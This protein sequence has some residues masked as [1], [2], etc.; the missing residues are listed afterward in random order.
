MPLQFVCP[1]GHR[2]QSVTEGG[3]VCP[4]CGAASGV[5]TAVGVGGTARGDKLPPP[6]GGD[7][8]PTL[9]PPLAGQR[10][11]AWP[12]VPGFEIRGVAG[13]GGM[14][15]VYRA[16]QLSLKREVAL[17][18]V[19]SDAEAGDPETT[20]F[21]LEAESVA[22]LNHPNVVHVYDIVEADGRLYC[23]LEYVPGGSL[24]DR[25]AAGRL[26]LRE[27]VA[28]VEVLARAMH[29]VHQRHIV[30][31]DLKPGNVLLGADGTLK[32]TDF[33]LAKRLDQVSQHTP[34]GAMLGTP[35]Y[36]APEQ[37]R[38]EIK[39]IGP[40]AD[41]YALGVIL[42]ELLT[43]RC[44]F[45]GTLL[46]VLLKINSDAPV[47]P[48]H[49]N[50][51]VP[52]E[53]ETICLKCMEKEPVRR[54]PSAAD[55]AQALRQ[56]LL[57]LPQDAPT[58]AAV[59]VTAPASP[60]VTAPAP[61]PPAAPAE[62]ARPGGRR[63]RRL[64]LAALALGVVVTAAVPLVKWAWD[65]I[66]NRGTSKGAWAVFAIDGRPGE[67]FDRIAFPG[68][69]VGYAAG[70]Q[71]VRK[72][73]DSGQTW[74]PV[75]ERKPPGRTHLLY[76]QNER[77]GWLGAERLYQTGD[78]GDTWSEVSLPERTGVVSGLAID[79]NGWALVGGNLPGP[80]G[81]L[82]LF[83]Q[84]GG[85]A[86]WE[87]LDPVKTG[88]WGGDQ[89][90]FRRWFVGD[91]KSTGPRVA[92]LVLLA[93]YEDRGAVLR[94]GD[95]GDTWKAVLT[96]ENELYR[97]SFADGQRGWLTG[98]RGALWRTADGGRNWAPQPPPAEDP[99]GGLAF[100]P[101]REVFGLAPLWQGQVLKTT[102]GEYW[103]TV[104][105][106]LGYS[107]PDVAVVDRGCAYVLS[108]DGRIARY[109]DPS[110]PPSK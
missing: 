1:R 66:H 24:K 23:A 68:R 94:T 56:V 41:V 32:I 90:P 9:F 35:G 72:T 103:Q 44:P 84:R 13:K 18:C 61:P 38:G 29:Y 25:L 92:L 27:A 110:V 48:S 109:L 108:A 55:L 69:A 12:A 40:A 15:L 75:W 21:R 87:K 49:L 106:D 17:K 47:P 10:P 77:V 50:A 88:Y 37:A 52:A 53:L 3:S 95:G 91:I 36:M 16:W 30:H 83:R 4:E 93:G 82:V 71:A 102:D 26:P 104:Q 78:G 67:V 65:R 74:R 19:L 85:Q 33:G 51:A 107:L 2:W 62:P 31:R 100:A 105:V 45:Q 43:G 64:V 20:R 99:L 6:A 34:D 73:E 54:Y 8:V 86:G 97:A 11:P 60:S 81:D 98:S 89:G 39:A 42:Y 63:L 5:D 28:L 7:T 58:A 80:R 101:G 76:F 46:E 57:R 79:G 96:P 59:P 14:G 22:R 70:R